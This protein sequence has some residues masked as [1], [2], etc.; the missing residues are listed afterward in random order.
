MTAEKDGIELNVNQFS[1]GEKCIM[2][3]IGDIARRLVVLNPGLEN[4]LQDSGVILIDEIDLHLH[5][6]WQ[7]EIIPALQRTFPNCQFIMTT[8][9]PQILSHAQPEN[10]FWCEQ[11][12]NAIL[13]KPVYE[14]YGLDSNRILEEIMKVPERPRD[15][16]DVLNTIYSLI[17]EN[18]FDRAKEKIKALRDTIGADS[19]LIRAQTIINRKEILGK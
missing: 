13:I 9:S 4:P 11:S 15:I 7:R 10:V 19:E 3:L 18:N 12:D 8:H 5:P 6:G 17:D 2:A 16:K 1:D 14:V